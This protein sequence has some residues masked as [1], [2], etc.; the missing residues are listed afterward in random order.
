MRLDPGQQRPG[1][2]V[3]I[4]VKLLQQRRERRAVVATRIER[5]TAIGQPFTLDIGK[6]QRELGWK[7]KFMTI[8]SLVETAWRW[9]KAKP[10]G[11]GD[12]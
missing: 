2:D 5:A 1:V 4:A 10:G 11:Y 12:R 8:D 3:S 9:H 6:A 7:P